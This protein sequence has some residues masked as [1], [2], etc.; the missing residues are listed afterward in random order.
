M[1]I[2]TDH[3]KP[4]EI[5]NKLSI[6]ALNFWAIHKHLSVKKIHKKML[7]PNYECVYVYVFICVY[8]CI[9]VC[10]CLDVAPVFWGAGRGETS[11]FLNFEKLHQRLLHQSP[12]LLQLSTKC[13]S[14]KTA[15]KWEATLILQLCLKEAAIESYLENDFCWNLKI[16]WQV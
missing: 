8:V 9:C 2:N 5:S 4:K 3:K 13:S 1:W 11:L 6:A 12:N 10:V 14:S 7:L 16:T 15:A